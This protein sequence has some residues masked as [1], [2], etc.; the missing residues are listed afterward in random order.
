MTQ[1]RSQ[2]E[3]LE[4]FE[5][6]MRRALKDGAP[7]PEAEWD[8]RAER[9]DE[10]RK[11][12]KDSVSRAVTEKLDARF[13]LKGRRILDVGAGTGRYAL[14]FSEYG[15]RVTLADFSANMLAIAQ[16]NLAAS[17]A[18]AEFLKADWEK[19]DPDSLGWRGRFDG[20][21]AAMSAA[22][23]SRSGIEKMITASKDWCC[24]CQY[25]ENQDPLAKE[26]GEALGLSPEKGPHNDRD[27][28]LGLFGLLWTLGF[29]PEISY[30]AEEREETLTAPEAARFYGGRFGTA[31]D[32]RGQNLETLIARLMGSSEKSF[33]VSTRK[34]LALVFWRVKGLSAS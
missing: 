34:T 29:S 19:L 13:G 30:L 21:F 4:R 3:A 18:E 27:M 16:K 32:A 20:V 28:V 6:L 11:I 26:L 24:V 33:P 23:R 31:A 22:V 10:A 8:A 1:E 7:S 14:L 2:S 15:A 5:S 12:R 17:G 25:I 9:Y